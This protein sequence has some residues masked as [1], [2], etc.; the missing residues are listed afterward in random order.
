MSEKIYGWLLKLYPVSFR[1]EYGASVMQLFRDRLQAER[2]I[3]QK[4]RL[5]IDVIADL[6]VSIPRE[7][8]RPKP[9]LQKVG[10]FRLS[11]EAVTALCRGRIVL[12]AVSFYVFLVLGVTA[13]WLGNS[14]HLLLLTAY[15]PLAILGIGVFRDFGELKRRWRSYELILE[16]DRVQQRQHG[17]DLTLSRS[18]IIKINESQHHLHIIGISGARPMTILV[19]ASLT[20]YQQVREHVSHWMPLSQRRELWLSDPR[21]VLGGLVALLPAVLL[22]RSLHWFL[23]VAGIYYGMILLLIAMN[24]VRPPRNSGLTPR[25]LG[26]ELPPPQDM[27]RRFKHICRWPPIPILILLPIVRALIPIPN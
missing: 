16:P 22:V 12:P 23:A 7:H 25:P 2:G 20:G 17:H 19:P 15:L 1:V 13:G 14:F 8:W 9:A 26:W 27:W 5:W 10:E 11:E 3:F 18:E 24:V 4:L 21:P 6:A